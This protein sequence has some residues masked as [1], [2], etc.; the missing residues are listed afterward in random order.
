MVGPEIVYPIFCMVAFIGHLN[1]E[2]ITLRSQLLVQSAAIRF[3][4]Y[5]CRCDGCHQFSSDLI[6]YGAA[7]KSGKGD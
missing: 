5:P 4:Q 6:R 2:V 7:S 3:S 1:G